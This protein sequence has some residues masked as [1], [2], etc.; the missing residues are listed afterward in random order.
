MVFTDK[1]DINKNNK[2]E[3]I[4]ASK[5]AHSDPHM[6]E[7]SVYE[8]KSF[9]IIENI[10]KVILLIGT[11]LCGGVLSAIFSRINIHPML[12][13]SSVAIFVFGV[14]FDAYLIYDEL[15]KLEERGEDIWE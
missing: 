15:R 1:N 3:V 13:L 4:S 9:L 5:V 7:I 11:L 8:I 14:I 10:A 12:I 6:I 2:S